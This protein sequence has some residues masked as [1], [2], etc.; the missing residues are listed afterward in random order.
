MATAAVVFGGPSPEHD[1]SV[2][3]GLQA[4]RL[5]T[6]AGR[7][8]K[9]IYWSKTAK[10]YQVDPGLEAADFADGVPAGAKELHFVAEPGAGWQI[11]RRPLGVEVALLALHGGP[12]EDGSLQG[13]L[14]LAGVRYSGPDAAGSMLGMDKLAFGAAV[15][16][17]G[18]PSLPRALVTPD[19][20]PDFDSPYIVKPRFGGS[21]IGIEVV[22]DLATAQALSSSSPHMRRGA[23]IEPFV[24][25]S[26]DLNIAIR[27]YPGLELSAIE[28]PERA[29][30]FYDYAEKYL[31]GGGLEGSARR[32]PADDDLPVG[33]V[34]VI[35]ASAAAVAELVGVRSV[36]RLDFLE[37]DGSVWV[38]E[39]NTI[40]GSLSMYLWVNPPISRRRLVVDLLTEVEQSKLRAFST[41][42]ADGMALRSAEAI[43][44][45]LG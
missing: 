3:T 24:E 4:A 40:P 16:N 27:T 41:A 29:A 11:R 18:L 35:H 1:I 25:G 14:D 2:L 31:S 33:M 23:V 19:T 37:H 26:R 32:L 13:A 39:I 44:K 28:A 6:D 20:N 10:W 8:I 36:A 30:G 45:K 43:S 9:A 7:Q 38:N 5:L 42:G 22:D 17:A 34:E 21:S 15:S 12:G